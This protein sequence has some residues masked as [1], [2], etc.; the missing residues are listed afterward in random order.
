M[1]KSVVTYNDRVAKMKKSGD[2]DR[3]LRLAKA[4][5]Q[6]LDRRLKKA[7]E[8]N[9]KLAVAYLHQEAKVVLRKL[10]QNICSL[11]DMLDNAEVNT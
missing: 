3:Q 9:D 1:V 6:L 10:R 4:Y 11:Q 5:V 7:T 8:A 2:E